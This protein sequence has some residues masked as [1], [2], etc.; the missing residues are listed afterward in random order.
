M[1]FLVS[2]RC[3]PEWPEQFCAVFEQVLRLC[4]EGIGLLAFNVDGSDHGLAC[5]TEN[6][7]N[8]FRFCGFESG[9]IPRI[10]RDVSNVN[11]PSAGNCSSR[12]TLADRE[13]GKFRRARAAPDNIAYKSRDVIDIVESNP[14]M[15]AA[16]FYQAGH[17]AE[18]GTPVCGIAKEL[19]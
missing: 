16:R 9:K 18:T 6:R 2:A 1:F 12:E 5:R 3:R 13:G 15:I 4:V 10:C 14:A 8:D 19:F 11:R 7:N 17:F